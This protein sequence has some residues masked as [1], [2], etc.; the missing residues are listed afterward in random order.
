METWLVYG[1]IA[2]VFLGISGFLIKIAAGKNGLEPHVVG[3]L[4]ALSALAI[5]GSYYLIES[6]GNYSI[7]SNNLAVLAAIGSGLSFGI[8]VA[9]VYNGFRLGANASQMIPIYNMNTLLVVLLAILLL[10]EIPNPQQAIKITAGAVMIVA[11][12][13]L[14]S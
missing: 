13:I 5:L 12:A 10:R 9:I 1:L 6:K 3:L 11:G 7:P 8:G 14:V 4:V 2:A